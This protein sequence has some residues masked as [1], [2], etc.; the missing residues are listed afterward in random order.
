MQT[1]RLTDRL[2]C[3]QTNGLDRQTYNQTDKEY[4][5][6]NKHTHGQTNLHTDRLT[7]KQIK[8]DMHIYIYI[9]IY[10]YIGLRFNIDKQKKTGSETARHVE[11]QSQQTDICLRRDGPSDVHL[12]RNSVRVTA[13]KKLIPSLQNSTFQST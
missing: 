11:K 8:T 4:S 1:D 3:R 13:A 5:L 6:T 2:T 12:E 10:I 7:D 9:Y